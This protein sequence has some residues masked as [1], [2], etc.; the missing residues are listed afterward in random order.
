MDHC[1]YVYWR[2]STLRRTYLIQELGA[3]VCVYVCASTAQDPIGKER[4]AEDDDTP[5]ST[6]RTSYVT[7]AI[8]SG[9]EDAVEN[10]HT[11]DTDEFERS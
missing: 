1:M 10:T 4:R 9:N 7:H 3:R 2:T 6:G 11:L 5:S 8:A